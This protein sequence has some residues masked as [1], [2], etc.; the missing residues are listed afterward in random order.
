MNYNI[1]DLSEHGIS[2]IAPSDPALTT[3]RKAFD[4]YSVVIRN[5][6]SRAVVGYSIKWQCFDGKTEAVGRDE[7]RDQ[8]FSNILGVV[9]MHGEE[10]ERKGVLT[11]LDGVIEPDSAW[12]VSP[13]SPAQPIG[14]IADGGNTE[15]IDAALDEIRAACPDMTVTADG[16]FFDDGTFIGPDTTKFFSKV[17]TQMDVRFEILRGFQKELQS[18]KNPDDIFK[19][20]EQIRDLEETQGGTDEIRSYFRSLFARDL[21]GM[22]HTFGTEKAI[23]TIQL[24]LSRRWVELRKL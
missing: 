20:L 8:V 15:V 19:G 17:K 4:P 12:L 3:N 13:N 22:K 9:F 18:G 2:L 5:D 10:S 16:I 7:S 24:Q 14:A 23:Q 21:L 1:K 11:R 6:S